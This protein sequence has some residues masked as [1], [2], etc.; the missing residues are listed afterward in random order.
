[1]CCGRGDEG[2]VGFAGVIQ[3]CNRLSMIALSI[4]VIARLGAIKD[5][6]H[7]NIEALESHVSVDCSDQWSIVRTES[8]LLDQEDALS[9]LRT[10]TLWVAAFFVFCCCE[11]LCLPCVLSANHLHAE[12]ACQCSCGS[13]TRCDCLD[14]SCDE[15]KEFLKAYEKFN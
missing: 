10:A 13:L 15:M 6:S 4:A 14:G 2:S 9:D 7:A 1:M 11:W 12:G 3:F 5:V 8:V